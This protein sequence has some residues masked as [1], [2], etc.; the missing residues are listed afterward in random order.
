LAQKG[1]QLQQQGQQNVQQGQQQ[2]QDALVRA[3]TQISQARTQGLLQSVAQDL[4]K[5]GI[6][7]SIPPAEIQR[8][9]TVIANAIRKAISQ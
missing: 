9:Q 8:I 5:V 4:Q 6:N 1:H 2:S 3:A 7:A